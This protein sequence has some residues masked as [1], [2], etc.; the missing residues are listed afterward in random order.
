[1][2]ELD[3]LFT[4]QEI[5]ANLKNISTKTGEA[6]VNYA[7]ADADATLRLRNYYQPVYEEYKSDIELDYQVLY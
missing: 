5:K 7:S 4:E 6:C 1:M 2:D 3:S